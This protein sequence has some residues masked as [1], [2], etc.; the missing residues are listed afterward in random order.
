MVDID[1]Y[2]ELVKSS[3][4]RPSGV[5][6]TSASITATNSSLCALEGYS[7]AAMSSKSNSSSSSPE[8]A[9]SDVEGWMSL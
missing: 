9:T 3:D 2:G 1:A 5:F 8:L 7:V 6:N 4:V